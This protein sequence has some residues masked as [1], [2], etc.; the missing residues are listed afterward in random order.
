MPQPPQF[1]DDLCRNIL[2]RVETRRFL[3]GFVLANLTFDFRG[4]R[5]RVG[6]SVHQ[7]LGA[8]MRVGS[9]QGLLTGSQ[10]PV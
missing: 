7:I 9:Q 6:P 5:A 10:T 3:R 8:Q 2:I 1:R 4:M